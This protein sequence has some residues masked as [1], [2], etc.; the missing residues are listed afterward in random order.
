MSFNTR[1][2]KCP[3]A[4][5]R[6]TQLYPKY[7]DTVTKERRRFKI[8]SSPRS[9]AVKGQSQNYRLRLKSTVHLQVQLDD[10][11]VLQAAVH[12]YRRG[13][14]STLGRPDPYILKDL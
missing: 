11:Y 6:Q 10:Q 5:A 7:I 13:L 12:V 14:V 1:S 9:Q 3:K 4:D 8:S 2:D